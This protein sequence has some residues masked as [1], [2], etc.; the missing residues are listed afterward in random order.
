MVVRARIT[1][2]IMFVCPDGAAPPSPEDVALASEI[3]AQCALA[4][5]N[6]RLYTE[7]GRLRVVAEASSRAKT[8]FLA[9]MSHELRTPLN[10]IGGYADL[11]DAGV[12][13]PVTAKQQRSLSRIKFSQHHL[14]TLITGILDYAGITEGH[15]VYH[16][17][18][19][20]L[21]GVMVEMAEM[22]GGAI[23]DAG[24]VVETDPCEPDGVAWADRDRVFQILVNLVT[25]AVKYA[26]DGKHITLTCGTAADRVFVRVADRGPGIAAPELESIFMPFVQL[27]TGLSDRKGGVG[28]GL[29]ISRDL[30][31][32]MGGDVTVKS[33]HGAG[34]TFTL[35]LPR[36]PSPR[37]RRRREAAD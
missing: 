6:A 10:V 36:A 7:A 32:G 20:T 30:A 5:D 34:T 14:L 22:L 1:G 9:T 8:A 2:V 16:T 11:I 21:S 17:A 19:V 12:Q 24:M 37:R 15:V 23:A 28:L 35:S 4:L 3:G 25:N 26:S 31:R 29:A 13:G 18:E 33:T 27:N